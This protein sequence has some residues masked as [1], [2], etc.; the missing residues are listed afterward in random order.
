[1][2]EEQQGE[3]ETLF[4]EK[5]LCGD[6]F[7][8]LLVGGE[9]EVDTCRNA[10]TAFVLTAPTETASQAGTFGNEA[11]GGVDDLDGTVLFE[12]DDGDDSFVVGVDRIGISVDSRFLVT[13]GR[14]GGIAHEGDKSLV[15]TD[16]YFTRAPLDGNVLDVVGGQWAIGRRKVMDGFIAIGA[17][18]IESAGLRAYPLTICCIDGN[19]GGIDAIEKVVGIVC[20]VV[21]RHLDLREMEVGQKELLRIVH[22]IRAV[23][24]EN[25]DSARLILCDVVDV[26][27]GGVVAILVLEAGRNELCAV[28]GGVEWCAS[29]VNAEKSRISTHGYDPCQSIGVEKD[30]GD[31]GQFLQ[32]FVGQADQFIRCSEHL[33]G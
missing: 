21:A 8:A 10:L 20:T 24:G 3:G 9:D 17:D 19:T 16:E 22:H 18:E 11:A 4:D 25:P 12:A 28:I 13:V 7:F 30:M 31:G 6:T 26:V 2:R 27:E 5:N 32:F 14:G 23:I 15:R 29:I 33:D 1:M